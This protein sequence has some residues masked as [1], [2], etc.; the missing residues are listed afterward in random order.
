MV[1]SR[2]TTFI[3]TSL[4]RNNPATTVVMLNR[5]SEAVKHLA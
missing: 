5:R 2:I 4:L 3:I 1:I